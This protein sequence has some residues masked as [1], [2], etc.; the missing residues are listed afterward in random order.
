MNPKVD[1]YVRKAKAWQPEIKAL[2][3]IALGSG[4]TE[5]LKWGKPCYTFGKSNVVIIIPLKDHVAFAFAKGAL[6]KDPKGVLSSIGNSQA[7]RWIKFASVREIE[8]LKAAL[9]SYIREAVAAEKAGLKVRYKET[10]EYEVP[11]E[12]E[13]KL[14]A[15]SALRE[16]FR[17]LTPGRQRGY[18]VYFA[19]AKQSKTRESRIEKYRKQILAGKGL[20]D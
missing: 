10:S 5:E 11:E 20:N 2:R 3:A 9:K 7:G 16:A 12:L 1:A 13:K 17:G 18:L 19:S 15:D 6:L 8:R 14:K 4:L